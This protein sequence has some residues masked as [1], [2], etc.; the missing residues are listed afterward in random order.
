MILVVQGALRG[1]TIIDAIIGC[2]L[3]GT[4]LEWEGLLKNIF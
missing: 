1:S 4:I 2:Y 3:A